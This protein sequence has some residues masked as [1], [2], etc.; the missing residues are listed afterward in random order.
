MGAGPLR[1]ALPTR[2]EGPVGPVVPCPGT[3]RQH[4]SISGDVISDKAPAR[5][6]KRRAE[7]PTKARRRAAA[8][9]APKQAGGRRADRP[10][11][12]DGLTVEFIQQMRREELEEREMTTTSTW[13]APLYTPPARRGVSVREVLSGIDADLRD[14]P[15]YQQALSRLAYG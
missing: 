8:K 7:P 1:W 13:A 2:Q 3:V 5:G 14:D 12:R 6:G 10:E 4:A 15:T 11:E 9:P